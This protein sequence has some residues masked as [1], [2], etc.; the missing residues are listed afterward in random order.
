[1]L[2][3][4]TLSVRVLDVDRA[5]LEN[6]SV[7][8][9]PE[10]PPNETGKGK[11]TRLKWDEKPRL[12]RVDAPARGRYTVAVTESCRRGTRSGVE[13]DSFAQEE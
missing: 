10:D 11:G 12:Y 6:A 7:H 1:M 3:T 2:T 8:L 13:P 9:L 4:S 5:T